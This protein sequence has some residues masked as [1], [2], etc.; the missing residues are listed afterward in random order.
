MCMCKCKKVRRYIFILIVISIMFFMPIAPSF[1]LNIN[2]LYVFRGRDVNTVSDFINQLIIKKKYYIY[3]ADVN[4]GFFHYQPKYVGMSNDGDF[5]IIS[6]NR[7][8]SNDSL[9]F[10]RC[11]YNSE[12]MRDI[13]LRFLE[14]NNCKYEISKDKELINKYSL[15]MT[16]NLKIKLYINSTESKTIVSII[17]KNDQPINTEK[18]ATITQ[19]NTNNT[20]KKQ[21]VA[22]TPP[23]TPLIPPVPIKNKLKDTNNLNFREISKAGMIFKDLNRGIVT[24]YSSVGH[25]S[26]FLIDESGLILTNYHVVRE[27]EDDLKVRFGKGEVLRSKVI[28]VDPINDV[29][30]IWANIEKIQNYKILPLFDPPST[31]PTVYVGESIVAIGS[32]LSW[33]D[34][35]KTLTQGVVGKFE[36]G[37]IMHD[38]S[39]NLGNS[40]GPLINFGGYVV[41]INSFIPTNEDNNGLSGAISI[42][43][44][45][46][47]LDN[48][49]LSMQNINKPS[50]EILPDI[51]SVSYNYEI[52]KNDYNNNKYNGKY[53]INKRAGMYLISA[54]N[55]D[56]F[57]V[58]PPQSY[59]KLAN[60]EEELIAKHKKR[61]SKAGVAFSQEE[62][63]SK[64]MAEIGYKKPLVQVM[65][66]PKPQMTS[67]SLAL[68]LLNI[69]VGVLSATNGGR[70][71]P[72]KTKYEYE[73]KKDF[74]KL[75]LL[76]NTGNLIYENINSGKMAIT[77]DIIDYYKSQ[78]IEIKDKSYLGVYEFDPKNFY[79][80]DEM[81]FKIYS[82]DGKPPKLIKIPQDFK[83]YIVEDFMPYWNYIK[84]LNNG[85]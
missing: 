79:N 13:L 49:F 61:L 31:E 41:G 57:L 55:Y 16:E 66:M 33:E 44:A 38:A 75:E 2:K 23:K 78:D 63:T 36:N 72:M 71:Y 7:T 59:R 37:I 34:Y 10:I 52:M 15:E 42:N 48:A 14:K 64:N 46:S 73:Y 54:G 19:E 21:V 80:N 12:A 70:Y 39:V 74:N 65:I 25:G 3:K 43:R 60:K 26:G 40:G 17:Q 81:A 68:G 18:T 22:I 24:V 6:V 11:N 9:V 4:Q 27:Q 8:E 58:T 47:C 1:A 29:A 77:S 67:A 5:I 83:N 82:M 51:P 28:S 84:N 62:Y 56:I 32:P 35:E 20:S 69:T 76:N 53:K 30:V 85:L 45:F 50:P